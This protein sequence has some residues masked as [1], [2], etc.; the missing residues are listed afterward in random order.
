M[1]LQTRTSCACLIPMYI[2]TNHKS[3]KYL[4]KF[5]EIFNI[6]LCIKKEDTFYISQK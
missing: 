6:Y 5:D 3:V 4:F 1:S 2:G